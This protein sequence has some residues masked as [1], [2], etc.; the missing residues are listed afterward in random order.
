M[1]GRRYFQ[2]KNSLFL[3]IGAGVLITLL[4][5]FIITP[6]LGL[7]FRITFEQFLASLSDPVV[8]NALI[9]SLVTASIST[10]VIILVGTPVA[11]INARHQYPGREIVDTLIDLPLVLPPTVA[12]LALLLA[13]GR[14]GLIGSIFYDYGISIAFTTLAVIIAQIFVSIPFYIRQARASFE[15]LDP[16]YEHAAKSLGSPAVPTF[17]TVILPLVKAGLIGGAIMSFARALGE[18]GATI[19]F[20]GNFQ[21]RTQT[22]PL[23]I[24]T[25]MQGDLTAAITLSVILII[26]SFLIIALVKF[27]LRGYTE[28]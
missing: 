25:A 13:F 14:M 26:I 16:M 18:F 1:M 4:V 20:A 5:V 3:T 17:F 2:G 21:G 27:K 22:M 9:L 10:L 28:R 23:A 11:W 12:G 15:Q 19:M 7:F 24:Y 6:I 8:W